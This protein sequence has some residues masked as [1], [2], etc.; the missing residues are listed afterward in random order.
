MKPTIK[1]IPE[2]EFTCPKD[3][4]KLDP[5]VRAETPTQLSSAPS[6]FC[7]SCNQNVYLV[8]NLE[9]FEFAIKNQVCIALRISNNG[10]DR[11]YKSHNISALSLGVPKKATSKESSSELTRLKN[12]S[13]KLAKFLEDQNLDLDS[14]EV[15]EM[16]SN[17]K[18]RIKQ[19]EDGEL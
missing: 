8:K 5:D 18:K 19:I 6:R 1:C 16:Q 3:W 14:N 9:E 15:K 11:K 13:E 17:V 10:L 7:T 4:E 2:F 12:R